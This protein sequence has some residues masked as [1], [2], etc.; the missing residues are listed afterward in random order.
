MLGHFKKFKSTVQEQIQ[1][2]IKATLTL[3]QSVIASFRKTAINFHYEFNIRHLAGVFQGLLLAQPNQFQDP[4]KLVRLWIH[5]SERIYGDRLVSLE[6]LATFKAQVADLVKKNFSKFN[7]NR[8]FSGNA[9]EPI[10]FCD[11]TQGINN[12]RFYD[13]MPNDKLETHVSDALKEYND[14]NAVMDLV[15][16]DDAIRHICKI[17]RIIRQPSGYWLVSEAQENNPFQDLL[18]L[19]VVTQPSRSL[20]LN[21]IT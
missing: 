7:L 10:I 3:H 1:Y 16:F 18:H 8:F 14:N 5:E 20:F 21:H 2:I 15:L 13:Q 12:D 4:E 17:S 6:H 19:Y 11:F 9:P